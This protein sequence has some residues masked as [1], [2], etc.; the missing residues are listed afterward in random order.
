MI[1]QI[2]KEATVDRVI[3]TDV[4]FT[5]TM[6]YYTLT[7]DSLVLEFAYPNKYENWRGQVMISGIGRRI[8]INDNGTS[9]VPPLVFNDGRVVLRGFH[10]EPSEIETCRII[11]YGTPEAPGQ[12]FFSEPNGGHVVTLVESETEEKALVPNDVFKQ[13]YISSVYY[14]RLKSLTPEM[15]EFCINRIANRFGLDFPQIDYSDPDAIDEL[16]TSL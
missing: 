9:T 14:D 3:V 2:E 10:I 7:P 6:M 4:S 11:F 16:F 15:A 5:D 12:T 1:D 8:K 13:S